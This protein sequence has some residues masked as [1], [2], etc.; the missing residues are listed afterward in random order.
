MELSKW[1][2]LGSLSVRISLRVMW[3][4]DQVGE[5]QNEN[6]VFCCFTTVGGGHEGGQATILI[7]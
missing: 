3:T 7:G 4:V 5:E 2:P 1:P 6:H